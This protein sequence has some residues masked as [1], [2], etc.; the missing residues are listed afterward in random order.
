MTHNGSRPRVVV[1]GIGTVN[2][3]AN[4]ADGFFD[5]L[6][7]GKSGI[8]RAQTEH[9]ESNTSQVAGHIKNLRIEDH[10][11]AKEIRRTARF[12]QIAI[13]AARQALAQAGV[14]LEPS[15]DDRPD[16]LDPTRIGVSNGTSLGSFTDMFE[17]ILAG[18][19]KHE[20]VSPFFVPRILPNMA[21]A[22]LAIEF[23]FRGPNDTSVTACAASTQSIGNAL[24][25][26]QG[27]A[28]EAML[29]GGTEANLS[30]WGIATFCAMRALTTANADP[31]RASRPFDL[32]RDGF[33]GAEGAG[34]LF[35]ESEEH[36]LARGA[37]ILAEV[38][39]FGS[40]NDAYHQVMPEASG[41]GPAL[42]MEAALRDAGVAPDEVGYINAHGTSTQLN[43]K[44]E[45]AA[46][47]LALG[48]HA[49]K[50]SISSTKSMIGHAL[51]G[52]GGV[53]AVATVLQLTRGTLHP[54]INY[55]NPDPECDLDYIPNEAR[56]ADVD[57]AMSNSFG[58]G[59][60][61][62]VLV[63]KR[64]GAGG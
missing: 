30:D 59:G 33:V 38:A 17:T 1:T 16:G 56:R 32:H 8:T 26:I 13:I 47:K 60:Q 52:A 35:V 39:G 25:V 11:D 61:N 58:F 5:A 21:G 63:F 34:Y 57:V 42:A 24:R 4:D 27:G 51:G 29:T 64:Y 53:E 6:V 20:R 49:K 22:G 10:L 9:P 54:T 15:T 18:G 2:P 62:A 41:R 36:A 50:V 48:S 37:T 14:D 28:A 44:A 43:D 12:T 45:T 40:S 46:I 31:E 7:E 19:P 55:E 3:I 23:G